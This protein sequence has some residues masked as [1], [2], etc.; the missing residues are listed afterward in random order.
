M[1]PVG[2]SNLY[3]NST[4]ASAVCPSGPAGGTSWFD[5][6][7]QPVSGVG[8]RCIRDSFRKNHLPTPLFPWPWGPTPLAN[9]DM[10]KRGSR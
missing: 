9:E 4:F 7:D 2:R 6:L 10:L 1:L 5:A 8:G 3:A